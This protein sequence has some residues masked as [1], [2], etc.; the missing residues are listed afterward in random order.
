M[1]RVLTFNGARTRGRRGRLAAV[2]GGDGTLQG[3]VAT[4]LPRQLGSSV[5][6]W[7]GPTVCRTEH[8]AVDH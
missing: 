6:L 5:I 3:G 2:L 7:P 1:P 4:P 8:L